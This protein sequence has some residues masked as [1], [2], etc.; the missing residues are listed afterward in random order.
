MAVGRKKGGAKTGGRKPGTPNKT[1][2][3]LKDAI[4][5]AAERAG[6]SGGMVAYLQMQANANPGPFMAL[7][8]KVLPMQIGGDPDAPV[9]LV[10]EWQSKGS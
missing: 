2:A 6:G 4:L 7:L 1:T 8:G 5:T 3:L 9:K 10:I